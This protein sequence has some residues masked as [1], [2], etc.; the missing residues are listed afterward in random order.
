MSIRSEPAPV[1][2]TA[3]MAGME[4]APTAIPAGNDHVTATINAAQSADAS[5]GEANSLSTNH[6]DHPLRRTFVT[7]IRASL[8]DL[9]LRKAKGTWAPSAEALRSMLQQKKVR[10][11]APPPKRTPFAHAQPGSISLQ[12]TDLAGSAEMSGDLKSVV[13]HSMTLSSVKSDFDVPIGLKLTGVDNT[14]FSLTGEAYSHIVPPQTES[15]AARVLQK[16]DVALAYEFSRKFPGC[17]CLRLLNIARVG[18]ILHQRS[19]WLTHVVCV[20]FVCA[21]TAENL[22]E[23]GIHEVCLDCA[24]PSCR[25]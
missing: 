16:D 24:P 7:N 19:G 1:P 9:C 13:L 15:T 5:L 18:F 14:T 2:P 4:I 8:G 25:R 22:T 17:K 20:C 21:D 6:P 12:V 11:N 10:R 23:K 3:Q